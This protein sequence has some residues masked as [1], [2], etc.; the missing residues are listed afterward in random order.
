MNYLFLAINYENYINNNIIVKLNFNNTILTD[1]NYLFLFIYLLLKLKLLSIKFLK[2][3]FVC[4]NNV[5]I[6]NKTKFIK[7][8]KMLKLI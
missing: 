8:M 1:G 5:S 3:E 7:V 2:K 4:I 6:K